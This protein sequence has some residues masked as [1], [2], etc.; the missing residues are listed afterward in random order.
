V[1]C[2]QLSRYNDGLRAAPPGF[3]FWQGTDIT[4]CC[5]ES[6]PVLGPTQPPIKWVQVVLALELKRM[7]SE[8][9]KSSSS[10]AEINNGGAIPL[11]LHT[12][13]WRA[14]SLI[15]HSDKFIF[16]FFNCS[17]VRFLV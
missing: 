15:K 11:L 8:V 17:Y 16:T 3:D 2:E 10:S 12:S 13:S 1:E 4:V 7:G 5:T 14:A 6:R 9:D